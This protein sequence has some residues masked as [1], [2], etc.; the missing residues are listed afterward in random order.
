MGAYETYRSADGTEI[1]S[2]FVA[3]EGKKSRAVIM[4]RG[5]AGPDTGY[6]QIADA[7]AADGYAALV[8]RWQVRGDDPDDA[9]LIADIRAAVAFLQG[10]PEVA[11]GPIA[12]FGYCKGGGQAL[13]AAAALPEIGP[14]VAFHGF[15]KRP[16]GPDATHGNPLDVAGDL[17][18]PVL[19]LHGE[20]DQLSP[21][22]LMKELA[23]TLA[24]SGCPGEIHVYPG[25]DHG[26]A[27]S[28]HK[29][30]VPAAA[31]DGFRRGV[32][33]LEQYLA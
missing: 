20:V 10:R 3:P 22:P 33:F 23:R 25:A 31:G 12:V 30:F 16:N 5:V 19:L 29:G 32:A 27:V 18:R 21:L 28:T 8:H 6:S 7:L 9:T 26:F 13:L 4:L 17:K 15:S 14:V 1:S 24:A 2:Y 11:P